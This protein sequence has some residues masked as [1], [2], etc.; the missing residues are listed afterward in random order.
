MSERVLSFG[1]VITDLHF[2]RSMSEKCEGSLNFPHTC[3]S[4]ALNFPP[5]NTFCI[6]LL[7]PHVL[8]FSSCGELSETNDLRIQTPVCQNSTD[9]G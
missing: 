6:A 9:G 2:G 3:K 1:C 5:F 8:Q 7:P 4:C